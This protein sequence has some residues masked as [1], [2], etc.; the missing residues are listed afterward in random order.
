MAMPGHG[1]CDPCTLSGGDY[2]CQ[3]PPKFLHRGR[4]MC[5]TAAG[6]TTP[7]TRFEMLRAVGLAT[8]GGPLATSGTMCVGRLLLKKDG[9]CRSLSRTHA[10]NRWN[11]MEVPCG[12]YHPPVCMYS[13]EGLLNGVWELQAG[14]HA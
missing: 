14:A 7:L 3:L 8:C 5:V 10:C 1:L 9:A 12:N 13:K 2:L 6:S 4:S 11:T